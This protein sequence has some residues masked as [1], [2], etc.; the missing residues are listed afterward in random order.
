M[1][2][3]E[4]N[5]QKWIFRISLFLLILLTRT[6]ILLVFSYNKATFFQT[7]K[8]NKNSYENKKFYENKV[9]YRML[10]LEK[11]F[12]KECK[13]LYGSILIFFFYF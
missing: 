2:N 7:V 6:T 11:S 13:I 3:T 9:C 12:F 5:T 4:K 10:S 8:I 1:V